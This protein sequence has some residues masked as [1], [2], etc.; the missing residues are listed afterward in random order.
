[1]LLPW[2]AVLEGHAWWHIF[3]GLGAYYFIIWRVWLERCLD[4]GEA[5]YRLYWPS[6]FSS[7]PRVLPRD[8]LAAQ[9]NGRANGR[10]VNGHSK[11]TL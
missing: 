6:T 9:K 7:V 5:E 4:G 3:T 10:G 8:G 11:K 2:A 1:M